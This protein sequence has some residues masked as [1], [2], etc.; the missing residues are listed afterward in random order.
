[1]PSAESVWMNHS[2][3]SRQIGNLCSVHIQCSLSICSVQKRKKSQYPI[4]HDGF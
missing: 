1:M 4:E 2:H 3:L